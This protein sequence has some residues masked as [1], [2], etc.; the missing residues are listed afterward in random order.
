MRKDSRRAMKYLLVGFCGSVLM[1]WTLGG[2]FRARDPNT[3]LARTAR[4]A[5]K[6]ADDARK[7]AEMIRKTSSALRIMALAIGVTIPLII[8]YLIYLQQLRREPAI[9]EMLELIEREK[10]TDAGGKALKK[11]PMDVRARL[12]DSGSEDHHGA[13]S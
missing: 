2:I 8:A 11:L 5:I 4:E 12:K 1:L 3:E 6:M 13:R 10:L 7:E 9:D